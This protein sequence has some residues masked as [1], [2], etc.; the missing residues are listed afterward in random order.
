MKAVICTKYG[1]PEVLQFK[2]IEKP[3]PKDNELLIKVFATTVTVADCRVRGFI[4]P[5]SFWLPAKFALGFSKPRQSILG[6][7]LAGVVEAVGN[8][9]TN[10][11]AGD[12]VF[13][14]SE[15]KLG[16]YAE[17]KCMNGNE[18]IALKPESLSFGQ[19][20]A[21]PFGG[22]TALYFCR[23]ANISIDKKVLVYGASGSVGTYAAQIAKYFGAEVT[24]VCSSGNAELVKGLGADRVIDYV[25][26]EWTVLNEKF[27][28]VFDA[29]GKMNID[30][31]IEITKPQGCYIHTVATP[32]M[33]I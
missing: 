12:E 7:E 30:K 18:L 17:Y 1:T 26:D 8:K 3:V 20:V 15:H 4:V 21:L 29:V 31:V 5:K 13:A 23:K 25:K 32:F 27:D 6:S 10:F 28:V 19:A 22:I 33:E 24:G 2:E 14:F 9:V 11:K 16:A